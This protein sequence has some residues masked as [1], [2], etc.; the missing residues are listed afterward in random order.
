M[1]RSRKVKNLDLPPN[2]Y[3][4]NGYYSYRDPRTRKEYGLG[5][6][7]AYAINEAISANQLLLNTEKVKP[8]TERIDGQGNVYFHE[9]LE[10]Y[11]DILKTRGLREK[12]LK[13]Y[14]QRIGVIR[15]AFLDT[16][17][18]NITTKNIADF[19]H[20]FI[21]DGKITT[22][23]ALRKSLIDIFKEALA[24]GLM[25]TNPA[26]LTETPK[27]KIMRS[28]LSLNDFNTIL[29]SIDG[30]HWLSYAMKLALI[31]SQ[32]VSDISKMKWEDIHDGKLWV[33]QQK[34]ETKIA[35][36]LDIEIENM[37]LDNIIKKYK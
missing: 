2:L 17:I 24:A 10:R 15:K 21:K 29:K 25:Q 13:D 37:K 6:N 30:S 14:R 20:D 32:R 35:I 27:I 23:K 33:I 9:F 4:R 16:P 31:T 11:E 19:L 28:R 18:Q 3:K 1:T 7:K 34:T 12:T 36:P 26:E 8:L 22:S 5:R